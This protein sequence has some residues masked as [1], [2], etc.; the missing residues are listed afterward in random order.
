MEFINTIVDQSKHD[1]SLRLITIMS[2]ETGYEPR[3]WGTSIIGFGSYHYQY[4]SRHHGD[5][6]LAGFSPRAKA[7]SIYLNCDF[8]KQTLLM[9]DLG[10]YKRGKS[11]IYIQKLVDINE[12]VLRKMINT[13]VKTIVEK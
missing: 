2:S 3:L 13:S 6:P 11:C 7:I 5:A 8:E 9:A 10:K 4:K 1:D 12:T